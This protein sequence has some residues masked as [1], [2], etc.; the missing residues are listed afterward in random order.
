[1]SITGAIV[2]FAVIWFLVFFI[3]LQIR[4][5]SQAEEGSVVKGTPPGA[6]AEANIGRKARITTMITTPIWAVVCAVILSGAISIRDIDWMN[7]M[8]PETTTRP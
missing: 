6:P 7:R 5:G 1:M 4:P 2:L 3:V 8:G